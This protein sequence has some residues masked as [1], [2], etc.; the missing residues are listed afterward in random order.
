MIP[1]NF[2][3]ILFLFN[4]KNNPIVNITIKN[5]WVMIV[6]NSIG[7]LRK[8]M[9]IPNTNKI[10]MILEPMILPITIPVSPY[11]VAARDAASSG[12]E[13]PSATMDIPITREETPSASAIPVA[14]STKNV[15]PTAS[16]IIPMITCNT[17]RKLLPSTEILCSLLSN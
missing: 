16:P 5:P 7:M 2:V 13:V 4:R 1:D 15:A 12:N 17:K 14:P 3:T 9:A 11:L 6:V 8:R 10:F